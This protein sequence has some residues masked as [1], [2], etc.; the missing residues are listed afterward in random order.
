MITDDHPIVRFGLSSLLETAGFKVV[1]QAENGQDALQVLAQLE[2]ENLPDVMLM[3]L[4]MPELDGAQTTKTVRGAYPSIRV[5]I[6]T[7]YDSD[8]DIFKAIAAGASGYLLKDAPQEQLIAAVVD[9]ASGKTVLSDP[10]AVK[11]IQNVS[12]PNVRLTDRELQVLGLVAKGLS[13]SQI[14][15]ELYVSESTV[16]TH[17]LRIFGKLEVTDRTRAVTR[18]QELGLWS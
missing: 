8:Q 2:P 10:V 6:L 9:A 1:A 17:L 5:L 7:T 12:Q 14:G 4:R 11:L 18:A 16:K 13:N 3:D 15:V